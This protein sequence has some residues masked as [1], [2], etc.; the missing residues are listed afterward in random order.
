MADVYDISIDL[1]GLFDAAAGFTYIWGTGTCANDTIG[2]T[3]AP[4][5]AGVPIPGALLLFGTGLVGLGAIRR[6]RQV[7]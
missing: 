1:S 3:V 7:V 5:A 2:D 4:G 6:R